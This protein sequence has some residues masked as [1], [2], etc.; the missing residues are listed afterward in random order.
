MT[1]DPRAASRIPGTRFFHTTVTPRLLAKSGPGGGWVRLDHNLSP[2]R[3]VAALRN[4]TI[5]VLRR[6]G[7]T[8]IAAGL[9]W[10]GYSFHHPLTL[11]GPA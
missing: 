1:A 4:L 6:A 11:P 8:N 7:H 9:R 3:R 2:G 10:A 5:A